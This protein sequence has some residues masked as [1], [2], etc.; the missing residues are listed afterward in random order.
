MSVYGDVGDKPV[1]EHQICNPLS[2]Y[3][4]SKLASENYLR[5]YQNELPFII[6]RMFNV[7]G[8]GQSLS[9]L[10]QGMV[11]IY[12]AHALKNNCIPIKGSLERFRDFIYIDDVVNIWMQTVH[13]SNVNNCT[14]NLGTG[15]KTFVRDLLFKI[16]EIIPNSSW[17]EAQN[18]P[19][20]QFGVHANIS[21]LK[22]TFTTSNFTPFFTGLAQFIDWA[23]NRI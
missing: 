1:N 8:P 22:E 13:N 19:G 9:N 5:I 3:G 10:R 15:E 14:F 4:V 23:K 21:L 7:Y 16:K 2:C 18:T 11:S 20:D 17:V 6:F 12:L